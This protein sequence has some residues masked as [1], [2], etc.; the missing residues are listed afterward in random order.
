MNAM[1]TNLLSRKAVLALAAVV[2]LGS[3]A[4]TPKP[5]EAGFRVGI[6]IRDD[7]R[8]TRVT[9]VWVAPVYRTVCDRVWIAD[10]YQTI[11]ERVWV[12][13]RY[14]ERQIVRGFGWNRRVECVRVL[15]EAAHYENCERQVLVSA[16]HWGQVERQELVSAGH[17]EMCEERVAYASPG[18]YVDRFHF[19]IGHR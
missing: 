14:E 9:R 11:C 15:V 10:Q 1:M 8:P 18:P 13:D 16:G 17:W 2:G 6:D 5:A 19:D 3:V 12:P 4:A 7:Y